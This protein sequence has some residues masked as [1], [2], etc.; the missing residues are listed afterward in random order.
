MKTVFTNRELPHIWA[1][2]SQ[3]NGRGNNFFFE[4]DTI[5]SYGHHFPIARHVANA[6]GDRAVLF[7]TRDY[8]VTT[9]RHK[10]LTRRACNG[11]V[12]TVP[13][14]G[15]SGPVS[16]YRK[17]FLDDY[18]TRIAA[19]ELTVGRSRKHTDWALE[20]L[21]ALVDE[22]NA[23]ADFA[24]SKRTFSVS[25]LDT[26]REQAKQATARERIRVAA[27]QTRLERVNADAIQEWLSG[28]RSTLPYT[29]KRIYLRVV[30]DGQNVETS[31]GA[32]IPMDHAKRGLRFVESIRT[33]GQAYQRNGHTFHL[34]PYAIDKIDTHGNVTA[35]CHFV[36]W[37]QIETIIERLR[38]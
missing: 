14:H 9:Q 15:E 1:H 26:L 29:V 28:D 5:Y 30:T 32:I 18:Q 36:E 37:A 34:G 6:R 19:Q 13:F 11:R 22:A 24:G 25:N 8:S 23:F 16:S 4:G 7:T 17:T 35:G 12:F 27:E 3:P 10:S 2:Q 20:R 21:M 31:K 38:A 33:S